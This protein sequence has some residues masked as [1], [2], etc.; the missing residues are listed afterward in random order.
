MTTNQSVQVLHEWD[1]LFVHDESVIEVRRAIKVAA[2]HFESETS[3]PATDP[4]RSDV[5]V[6]LT[7]D[8]SRLPVGYFDDEQPEDHESEVVEV[9]DDRQTNLEQLLASQHYTFADESAW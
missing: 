8:D 5:D 6:G 3:T 1:F 4:A 7:A 2:L 9:D